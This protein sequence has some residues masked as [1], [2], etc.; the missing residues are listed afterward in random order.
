MRTSIKWILGIASNVLEL[1]NWRERKKARAERKQES[2]A[3]VEAAEEIR[4]AVAEGD[5]QKVNQMLEEARMGRLHGGKTVSVALAALAVAGT[6]FLNGCV[7]PRKPLV[8]SADRNC[9]RMELD[10]VK[11]WF[12]PEAEFSDL[13]AA[14]VAESARL[15]LREEAMEAA[16][17]D[18]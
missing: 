16:N 1:L 15:K 2:A 8:L 4:H 6:V 5:E 9:V 17:G 18:F 10:G 14:Y 7:M 12:V 11:G 13:T 3:P